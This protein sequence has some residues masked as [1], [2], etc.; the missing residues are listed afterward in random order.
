MG[1]NTD[2]PSAIFDNGTLVTCEKIL[3]DQINWSETDVLSA[4]KNAAKAAF[5]LGHP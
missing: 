1:I 3:Q 4:Y 5:R 2:D